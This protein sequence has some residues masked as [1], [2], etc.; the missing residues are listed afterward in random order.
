MWGCEAANGKLTSHLGAPERGAG[1]NLKSDAGVVFAE[2]ERLRRHA[3]VLPSGTAT[4]K[5]SR[6]AVGAAAPKHSRP[7]VGAAQAVGRHKKAPPKRGAASGSERSSAVG[8]AVSDGGDQAF[9]LHRVASLGRVMD[10]P[11]QHR[12]VNNPSP[13]TQ[14]D[15]SSDAYATH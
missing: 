1:A 13:Q 7:A 2:T 12:G 4:L 6:P 10:W 3:A 11:C 5:R 8:I 14:T 9:D 15:D